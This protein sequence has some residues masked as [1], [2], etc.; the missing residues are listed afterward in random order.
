MQRSI[1]TLVLIFIL[2][3]STGWAQNNGEDYEP[4]EER[5]DFSERKKSIMNGNLLRATYHNFGHAGRTDSDNLD[6]ILF[7]YPRN[8]GRVYMY[9]MSVMMG[10]EV[11]NQATSNPD[12]TFPIVDVANYR[13][14]RAGD[15]WNF[16]PLNG[17]TNPNS[18]EIARSDRGPG[19]PLGNTWPSAWP[20]K[21]KGGGDGWPGD[22]NGFFGRNQFN[23]D[24]EFFYRAGDDLYTRYLNGSPRFRPDSTD[25]T[26]GGLG[27]ILDTRV[28]AWSQTLINQAHF[29][30]FEVQNDASYNYDK[31]AFGLWIA[32][33]VA[34][35]A[36]D[37]QPQF[38]NLRSIAYLTDLTRDPAPEEFDGG[39]VGEMGIKFLETPGNATDGI[40]ND[41]DSDEYDPTNS[42][43][44]N[45]DNENLYTDLTVSAG[46]FHTSTTLRDSV[47]PLFQQSD[48]ETRSMGP[49][50]KIVLI[51]ENNNRIVT[52]YPE[53]GGEVRSQGRTITLPANGFSIREDILPQSDP[54]FG[55]HTDLLDNDL[56]G[57]IDENRPNHLN[58]STFVNNQA[59]TRAVRHINYLYFDVGDT[60]QPGMIVSNQ[61][62][63]ER[64]QE[65]E[66]FRELVME[67]HNGRF[68]N[69]YT[70]APMVDEDRDDYFDN[71]QDWTEQKD[72]VGV[73]GDPDTPSRGQGDGKPTSGAGT[74]FPGE[75]NIDKTDV[76]ETDLLGVTNVT[77]FGA[78]VLNVD[79][80]ATN[81]N[82]YLT[83]GTFDT[84][85][86]QGQDSDIFVS[87][88][89]FPLERGSSE[90]FAV[91]VTGAQTN[92]TRADDRRSVN[93]NLTQATKAYEADYQF[94]TAPLPPRVR[95][96]A[97]DG[98]VTLYW[99][100]RSEQSFDRYINRITGNGQDFEGYRI[101]R[102][103]DPAF[104][105]V[106]SITDAFGNPQFNRPMQIF[107]LDDGI[108]GLHPIPVNG[109]KFNMGDDTGLQHKFVDSTVTNGKRYF[110]AVTAFDYGLEIAGIAPSESPISISLQ[111]DGSFIF[112]QNVV[113]VR[114][115]D[116]QA[117]Y[118]TPENPN[119]TLISGS[120]GGSVT[121]DVVDP[122]EIVAGNRYSVVF[123]DTIVTDRQTDSDMVRTKNF[124]LL[125]ITDG[126]EDTLIDRSKDFNGES[127]PVID[128]FQ[129]TVQNVT[130]LSVN[131]ELSKWVYTHDTP[132]HPY[133]FAVFNNEKLADYEVVIG[134]E[135]GFGQSTEYTVNE[136]GQEFTLPSK[137]TNFRIYN[138]LEDKEIKY[139]YAEPS[140]SGPE[141]ELSA[142]AGLTG[143]KTDVVIFVEEFQGTPDTTTYRLQLAPQVEGGDVTTVNPQPGDTLKLRTTKPFS[144]RDE[145]R[146]Q[147]EEKNTP[148]VDNQQANEELDNIK[149]VPNPYVVSNPYEPAKT[150]NNPQQQRELHFTHIPVPSTLRIFTVSGALVREIEIEKND[151][152]LMGGTY[153]GTYVWDMLTKDNL[154]ISYGVYIYH[155]KAPGVGETTGKFAVIK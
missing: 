25:P 23:A 128:G 6:E 75:P 52:R 36:S 108:S 96:V 109:V 64:M 80:D 134:D 151:P 142:S 59:I 148:R 86:E 150:T 81:W 93:D 132:P 137:P 63:R 28:M 89:V 127:I 155:I 53:G 110:Y 149:V 42:Q 60:L 45:S 91:A 54:N 43:F 154:E 103:T 55:V 48:F 61:D 133:D 47:V 131:D 94:A 68:Q 120:P 116:E 106:K 9:F 118:I 126:R 87:S 5:S 46:G 67:F 32:D 16:N 115:T 66:D 7:E 83:P 58:K 65:D 107:D 135:V 31:V 78:G 34:G 138:T 73:E 11:P 124:S 143:R 88:G 33:F 139:A 29:N 38:D 50:D 102:A 57:L 104:Q 140:G 123:E 84:Q 40:D 112:G 41:G 49:G 76:S 113:Q 119:A 27:L 99:D 101:Y 105:D 4:S 122:A 39:K 1:L 92:G 130:E 71:D 3:L 141:G 77:I 111:P 17:Y 82:T 8:T 79:Q 114:A 72:D 20:D 95:A 15:S 18:D 117:G 129:L 22:W 97:S 144:S 121:A 62:V 14:S 74:P 21:Q 37:D 125:N 147:M 145:F 12:D 35:T 69:K 136:Q 146:F 24:V 153:G 2:G 152:R 10:A 70:S 56:D 85:G 30:I 100:D 44:Y 26:R 13:T 98:K 90:R 19:S 51:A